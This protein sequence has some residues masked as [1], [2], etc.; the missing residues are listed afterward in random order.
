[1]LSVVKKSF[2]VGDGTDVYKAVSLALSHFR[3]GSGNP[4]IL[5]SEYA[6]WLKPDYTLEYRGHRIPV[7]IDDTAG[8]L[9]SRIR[10]YTDPL[11]R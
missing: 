8:T 1:M 11:E 5:L 10:A 3:C 6:D 2:F 4:D 9:E 7:S